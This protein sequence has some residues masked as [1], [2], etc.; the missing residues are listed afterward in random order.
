MS[1][2][3]QGMVFLVA[4]G[5]LGV[6]S[7]R[8]QDPN[9][10]PVHTVLTLEKLDCA[11]CAKRIGGKVQEV[12]GVARIQYDVEKKLLW[13]HPQPGKQP[14]PRALWEAAEKANGG[15]TRL[16]GPYGVYTAKPQ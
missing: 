12:P 6:G 11:S 16:H 15:P 8:G 4:V 13:V 10:P 3:V 2:L 14:S 9:A 7:I 1:K 5:F